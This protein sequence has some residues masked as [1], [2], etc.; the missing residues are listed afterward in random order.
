MLLEKQQLTWRDFCVFLFTRSKH[1]VT[2]QILLTKLGVAILAATFIQSY[3]TMFS[4]FLHCWIGRCR[5][6]V[7][8]F[9][10]IAFFGEYD[11]CAF[12][13]SRFHT[14]CQNFVLDTG[15]KSIFIH[16]LLKKKINVFFWACLHLSS[17]ERVDGSHSSVPTLRDILIFFVPPR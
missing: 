7:W 8:D 4:Q 13:P 12:F 15:S 17:A 3:L 11:F 1:Q 5:L 2:A 6:V 16:N 9:H 14:Y 10:L